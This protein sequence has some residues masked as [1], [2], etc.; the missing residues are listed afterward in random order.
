[1]PPRGQTSWQRHCV[2]R[3]SVCPSV[4]SFVCYQTCEHSILQTNEL[5]LMQ[6]DRSDLQ[7]KD[8][9]CST[10]GVRRSEVEITQSQ[11]GSQ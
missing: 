2:L 6:T 4:C 3:L 9:K 10:L 8:R 5:I 1:M 7:G 11:N